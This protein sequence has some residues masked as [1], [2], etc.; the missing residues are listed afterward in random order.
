MSSGNTF[1]DAEIQIDDRGI[2][3]PCA[4]PDD[5]IAGTGRLTQR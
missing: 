2:W 4:P 1:F 5:F 3:H